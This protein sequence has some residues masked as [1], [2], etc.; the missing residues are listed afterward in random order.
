MIQVDFLMTGPINSPSDAPKIADQI[1]ECPVV[2]VPRKGAYFNIPN[3]FDIE[4]TSFSGRTENEKLATMYAWVAGFNGLVIIGR[5]WD[6]FVNTMNIFSEVLNLSLDKRLVVYVHNLAFEFEFIG[7]RFEW[8]NVFSL[9]K[10]KPVYALTKNGIEFR[11]SYILSRFSLEEMGKHLVRY[12]TH[13]MVGDLDY[14]KPRHTK[15]PLTVQEIKYIEQDARVV[16][17]YIQERIE[18]DGGINK[19]PLTATGYVRRYCRSQALYG[20]QT[21]KSKEGMNT[22]Y[23]Y[24]E[25]MRQATLTPSEYAQLKRAFQGGFTHASAWKSGKMLEDVTSYDFTSSYPSVMVCEKFPMSRGENVEI[26]SKNQFEELLTTHCCLFDVEIS[27]LSERLIWEHP[28]SISRCRQVVNEQ[29]DNGRLARAEHLITTI[30][31]Q[32]YKILKTFYHWDEMKV[33]NFR[34]Y[35]KSYLPTSFVEAVLKVYRD[36]TELKGVA[37]R[38]VDYNAVK[39]LL[40]SLYGMSVTD[41]VRDEVIYKPGVWKTI[42]PD[43][44]EVLERYNTDRHRFLFYPWGVWVTAYARRNLFSGIASVGPDY[45]YSDTD[46]IKI[47]NGGN[48]LEYIRK[49][50]E[51]VKGKM[52][53]AMDYHGLPLELT[54]PRTIEGKEKPLGAWDYDG[55]YNLFKTLGAKRYLTYSEKKGLLMTVAGLGKRDGLEYLKKISG[56]DIAKAFK[57]FSDDFEVPPGEAGKLTHT[58]IMEPMDGVLVDYLSN[59]GEYHETGGVHLEPAGYSMKLSAEYAA[60]LKGIVD[61]YD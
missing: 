3:A 31:E 45:V 19:I 58:Y 37:G 43:I 6:E 46:S 49:Y 5:T 28:L 35:R 15:T 32:D 13:K 38:E 59:P 17:S 4:T 26:T 14:S 16:M 29:V 44:M 11:C 22:Y 8:E 40:N 9:R 36:K 41:I 53:K 24:A 60:F 39:E 23:R 47:L 61:Q 48:H 50:N 25:L 30:T 7:A 57:L 51:Q 27:G 18:I 1:K 12:P 2:R 54:C 10:H 56:G 42:S 34:A 33:G 52:K 55:H 20:G 21:H